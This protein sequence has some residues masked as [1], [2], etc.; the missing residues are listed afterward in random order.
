MG[1]KA[2]LFCFWILGFAIG[3]AAWLVRSPLIQFIEGIGLG[4]EVAQGLVAGL[5]GSSVMLLA[6]LSWSF[7]SEKPTL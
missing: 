2:A 1:R 6:V 7:L 5:F 3:A 4:S